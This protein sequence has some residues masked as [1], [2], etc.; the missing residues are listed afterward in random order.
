MEEYVEAPI[1]ELK[2]VSKT[3]GAVQALSKV[4]FDV[5]LGEVMALGRRQWRR[6]Q[7]TLIKGGCWNLPI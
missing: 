5:H 2:G 3:P 7:S 4:D 1:L 6:N